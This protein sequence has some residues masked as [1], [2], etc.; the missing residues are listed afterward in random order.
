MSIRFRDVELLAPLLGKLGDLSGK[1]LLTFGVQDC[2]FTYEQLIRFLEWKRI[3]HRRLSPAEI[4]P[5]TG[6]KWTSGRAKDEGFIHQKTLFAVLGFDPRKVEALDLFDYEGA[7]LL[8]DLNLPVPEGWRGRYDLVFDGG[9]LEHVFSIK[10]VLFNAAR[11]VRVGGFVA[12]HSPLDWIEHGFVNVNPKLYRTFYAAN[13]FEEADLKLVAEAVH[14][15]SNYLII[16]NANFRFSLRPQFRSSIF[17]AF[18]KQRE[19][20]LRAPFE[21]TYQD[22]TGR[23]FSGGA[24]AE[25]KAAP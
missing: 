13:G 22:L 17:A 12:H 4:L 5:T 9:V 18:G 11:L 24:A 15:I 20:E 16:Q 21:G 14:D 2:N 10:E 25:P 1:T 8:H 7:N 3:A 6:Y 23:Q 19:V